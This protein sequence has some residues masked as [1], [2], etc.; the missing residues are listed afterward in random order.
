[1]A[2]VDRGEEMTAGIR[3]TRA[4]RERALNV[5]RSGYADDDLALE[6]FSERAE[7]VVDATTRQELAARLFTR[8]HPGTLVSAA[9]SRPD[10]AATLGQTRNV[11]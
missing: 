10:D 9:A 3:P 11:S 4:Q 1:M 5:P 2:E 8:L 7:R 6:E